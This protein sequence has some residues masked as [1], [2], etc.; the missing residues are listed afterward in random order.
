MEAKLRADPLR[1]P[2]GQFGQLRM[3]DGQVLFRRH[4]P[5][6][7]VGRG[8]L[9]VHGFGEHSGRYRHIATWLNARGWDVLGYDQRGHG[10]SVGQRGALRQPDDLIDDLA[11]VYAD[12]AA[13]FT[14]PPLLFGHSMGGLV[15][16]RAVLGGQVKPCAM[17]LSS[18]AL[19]IREPALMRHLVATLARVLPGLPLRKGLQREFLSHDERVK[20][21]CD[22]DPYCDNRITPRLAEFFFRAGPYCI[23]AANRLEVPSLLLAAGDDHVVD[24]GG[25]R[26]F[27]DAAPAARL[28]GEILDG[29]YH[30]VFNEVQPT[31]SRVFA[32]LGEW[33]DEHFPGAAIPAQAR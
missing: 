8:A 18:P 6:L 25:S 16:A 10:R 19:R 5:R 7:G 17:V 15:A 14:A 11:A 3:A 22:R 21:A 20:E 27:I 2:Q 28:R 4:W 1:G 24:P 12:Y 26:D 30:E 33:L 23:A 32:R 29:L 13:G 9:L 31:R